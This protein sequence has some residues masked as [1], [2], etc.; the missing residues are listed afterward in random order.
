MAL[1]TC[2][3]RNTSPLR[4]GSIQDRAPSRWE[5]RATRAVSSVSWSTRVEVIR[6]IL[7]NKFIKRSDALYAK[8]VADVDTVYFRG[9][10]DSKACSAARSRA[11]P[12]RGATSP[13][14]R[15]C[16]NT[17]SLWAG[18]L[19][20]EAPSRRKLRPAPPVAS[21]KCDTQVE[22]RSCILGNSLIRESDALFAKF[23]VDVDTGSF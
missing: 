22:V 4:A 1:L 5:L 15:P 21:N 17:L 3:Y 7:G 9:D 16:Q 6:C 11:L 14:T 23:V 10:D 8:F 20:D 12:R 2:P 13:L 19:Q 18:S